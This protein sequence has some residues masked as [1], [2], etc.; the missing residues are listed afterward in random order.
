MYFIN[1]LY[2]NLNIG[3]LDDSHIIAHLARTGSLELHCYK[4]TKTIS[5][6]MAD[7]NLQG[8]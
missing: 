4:H 7:L 3:Y 5:L 8:L 6:K 2:L 1:K